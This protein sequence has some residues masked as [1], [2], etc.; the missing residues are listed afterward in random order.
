MPG[1]LPPVPPRG[2]V[3]VPE[4]RGAL[5]VF[6]RRDSLRAVA[7]VLFDVLV[8]VLGFFVPGLFEV[9][10]FVADFAVPGFFCP[11]F[12]CPVLFGSGFFGP[13]LFDSGSSSPVFD[14][15]VLFGAVVC[16]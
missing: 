10:V 8:F 6:F 2:R 15:G 13:V 16:A 7:A 11:G 1:R 3:R 4:F 9:L 5:V 12:F 14:A